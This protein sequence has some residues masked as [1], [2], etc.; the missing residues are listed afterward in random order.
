MSYTN[1]SIYLSVCLSIYLSIYLSV[2]LPIY[3]SIDL[4]IYLSIDLSVYIYIYILR[5]EGG[6]S[7]PA[8]DMGAWGL[9]VPGRQTHMF[10]QVESAPTVFWG[11]LIKEMIL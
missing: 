1:I 9:S 10:F 8:F 11:F 6:S 2:Y 5:E 3:L 4:S 7:Q